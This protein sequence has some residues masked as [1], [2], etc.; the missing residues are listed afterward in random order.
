MLFQ[1]SFEDYIYI[2][3][4][5][6]WIAYSI[7]KGSQ[8]NKSKQAKKHTTGDNAPKKSIFQSF[9]DEVLVEEKPVPLTPASEDQIQEEIVFEV[10]EK[11]ETIYSYDDIYEESNFK[12]DT[13]VFEDKAEVQIVKNQKSNILSSIKQKKPRIDLRKAVVYSEILNK[14][15]F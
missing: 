12:E 14:R 1:A 4:G 7:Y 9:I 10:P 3:V 2:L 13:D 11:K 8:K 15:Y 6:V 5:V